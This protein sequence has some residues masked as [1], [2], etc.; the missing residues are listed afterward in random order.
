MIRTFGGMRLQRIFVLSLLAICWILLAAAGK[1][2]QG[3]TVDSFGV[4]PL[5]QGPQKVQADGKGR[6]FLLR[7]DTLQVYPVTKNGVLGEPMRLET[8]RSLDGPVLDAAMGSGPGNWLLRLPFEVRWFV[9]GKEKVLPPLAWMP[10]SV[11]YLRDTPVVSVI[12]RPAPVNGMVIVHHGEPPATAPAVL[13]LS[14]DRWSVLVEE[15]P[16]AQQDANTLTESGSRSILGDREG[17]LWAAR[18]YAYVLDRYSPAGRRLG[19]IVVEKGK[20]THRE[21][22]EV[23][24][25]AEVR[26]E[27]RARFRPFLGVQ[28]VSDLAEGLDHRIYLLVQ[29]ENGAAIDRYDPA[30]SSLDRLDLNLQ[31]PGNATLAAGRDALYLAAHSGDRGRWKLSW[32]ELDRASWK[33]ISLEDESAPTSEAAAGA[34]RKAATNKPRPS[35][36]SP[37]KP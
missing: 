24:V 27:D 29:E 8:A 34:P 5:W 16:P 9:D 10:A 30:R 18:N 33:N 37:G 23:G 31:L 3:A 15:T 11:A 1:S 28:K 36:A 12:P 2:E 7:G 25:P 6:V 4:A 20:A 26:S 14:G 13:A 35:A 32:D 17:K 22:R 21:A 19:R